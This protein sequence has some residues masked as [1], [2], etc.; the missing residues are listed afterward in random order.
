MA[1]NYVGKIEIG[2]NVKIWVDQLLSVH[3]CL[4]GGYIFLIDADMTAGRS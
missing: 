4:Q 3:Q 2:I 1:T